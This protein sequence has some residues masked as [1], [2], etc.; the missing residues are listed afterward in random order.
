MLF[1]AFLSLAAGMKNAMQ[2]SQDMQWSPVHMLQQHIDPW[3]EYLRGDPDHRIIDTQRPNYLPLLYVLLSPLALTSLPTAK[4]V[5]AG[6]NLVF[7]VGSATLLSR[8]YR[9]SR[10]ESATLVSLFLMA[11]ATRNAIG[12]GQQSLLVLFVWSLTLLSA[13]QC[14]TRT[15]LSGISYFKFNFS[16]PLALFL[17]FRYGVKTFILSLAPALAGLVIVWL[18][19]KG[20]S[21]PLPLWK[22]AVEPFAAGIHGYTEDLVD[23]NLMSLMDPL[24]RR[25]P[26][27]IRNGLEFAV[28]MALCIGLAVACFRSSMAGSIQ[29]QLSLL[30]VADFAFF[31]HH[32][33]DSVILLIP[34]CLAL[35]HYR[36]WEGKG[37]LL[38]IGYFFYLQKGMDVMHLTRDW[39]HYAEFIFLL[40]I[41]AM[42]FRL[43]ALRSFSVSLVRGPASA[44]VIE[45]AMA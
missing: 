12:N 11:T 14:R 45:D 25:L 34:F 16:P 31:K 13:E 9:M 8:S 43:S 18:W 15:A 17:L 38:L 5:W 6:C 7:A 22:L 35:R 28:A 24:L 20:A 27:I 29:W 3:A 40:C 2:H 41:L 23:P 26:E 19:L 39:M 30:A 4:L 10:W 21:H 1:A 37:I 33:Y 36:R 44:P 42:I 32:S